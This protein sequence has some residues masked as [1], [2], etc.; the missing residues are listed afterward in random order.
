MEQEIPESLTTR[1]E[2]AL[3]RFRTESLRPGM[4]QK[5]V[6]Q[7]KYVVCVCMCQAYRLL[8]RS[9]A[10]KLLFILVFPTA[11]KLKMRS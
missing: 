11:M 6:S 1:Y 10:L 2:F 3:T 9:A 5:A 4:T 8:L 7:L